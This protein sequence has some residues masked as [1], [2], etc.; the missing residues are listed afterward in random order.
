[1]KTAYELQCLVND[2]RA[3]RRLADETEREIQLIKEALQ[4]HMAE[5]QID[6]LTGADYTVTWKEITSSRF[7]KAA[8]IR[9]FGRD[10][11]DSFCRPVRS[12][13]FVLSA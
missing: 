1:M 7:D 11:Y 5:T 3:L 6:T 10:C 9:S 12:R 13:R 2:L 8:M 4:A